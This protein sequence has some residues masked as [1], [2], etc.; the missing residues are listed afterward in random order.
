MSPLEVA[1]R[2]LADAERN[3]E[4]LRTMAAKGEPV[5]NAL[6]TA[7]WWLEHLKKRVVKLSEGVSSDA[8]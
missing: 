3:V 5:G 2:D 6:A 4:I 1:R 8:P 7:E